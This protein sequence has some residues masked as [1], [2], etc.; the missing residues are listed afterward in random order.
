VGRTAAPADKLASISARVL[1]LTHEAPLPLVSG[2]RIRSFHLMRELAE[3]GHDVSL[4]AL[5]HSDPPSAADLSRLG[6]LGER[7]ELHEF[8]PRQLARRARLALDTAG[9]R[10]FQRRYF[11]DAAARVAAERLIA[12]LRPDAIVA[13]QLYMEPYL[14]QALDIPVIFDSHNVEERRVASMAREGG[15]RA[16]LARRQLRP[17]AAHEAAVVGRVARTWAVSEEERAHFELHAPGRV[18]LVPNGVDCAALRPRERLPAAPELLFLGR[19]DYG[20]NV[21]G[22]R[23]L[24]QDV[25]PRLRRRDAVIR[26]VGANPPQATVRLAERSALTVDVTGFV[27]ATAPYLDAARALVVSLRSGGG[28]RLKILEALARGVPVVT[29]S[30]GCEGLGLAHGHDALIAD[31]PQRLAAAVDRLLDDDD[32]CRELARNGRATVERRFDWRAIGDAAERSLATLTD[33][34]AARAGGV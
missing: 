8:A 33:G 24:L 23:H 9:G 32:L 5:V 1:F 6:G 34:T 28:T 11:F 27:A 13:G 10:P 15:V 25:A 2:A 20:P 19:M 29:T 12:E 31:E 18:D 3:R 16:L 7:V 14:P 21:D 30:L 17:V 26:I 4:F 22:V